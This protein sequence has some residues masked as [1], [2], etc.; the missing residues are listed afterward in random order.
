MFQESISSYNLSS[1]FFIEDIYI[2]SYLVRLRFKLPIK[3]HFYHGSKLY[4]FVSNL[5]GY[6]SSPSQKQ[7]VN[8]VVIYPCES[9]RIH[10]KPGDEYNFQITFLNKNELIINNFLKNIQNI[11]EFELGGDL[12]RKSVELISLTRIQNLTEYEPITGDTFTLRFLTPLRIERKEE[13]KKRGETLFDLKYFDGKHFFKL[14]YK[15]AA[16]LY[17]LNFGFFPSSEIPVN[18]EVEILD[19]YFIWVDSIKEDNTFSLGGIVGFIK[20]KADLNELWRRILWFGQIMHAGKSSAIGFGKYYIEGTGFEEK[21]VKPAKTYSQLILEKE[22]LLTA[23][24]HIKN[25]SEFAGVDGITPDIYE[26]NLEEN[27][28]KLIGDVVRD[29]YKP[30]NLTGIIVPKS[31]SKIRALAIPSVRD[32]IFQRA[33]VQIIGETI[34]NLLEDSSYVY[35]KGLSRAGAAFAIDKARRSG[36]N[37]VLEVDIQSFFD[38]VDWEILFKKIDI[39]FGDDPIS[40]I[41]KDWISC[42]VLFEGITIK[43]NKGLPQGA[44]ISPILANLYL[45]EFDEELQNEFKLVRYADDFVILCKSKEQAENALE[46]VKVVL[47][48]LRLDIHPSKTRITT[49]EEGFQYLGYLFVNSLILDK[50]SDEQIN[51]DFVKLELKPENLPKSSWITLIDFEKIKSIHKNKVQ[52]ITPLTKDEIQEL[53]LDKYPLYITKDINLHLDVDGVEVIYKEDAREIRK[54]YPLKDL[55]SIVFIGTNKISMPAVFKLNKLN[56]P[57]YFCKSTGELRLSIPL[58]NPDYTLWANQ[59]ELTND[60]NFVFQFAKEIVRA[61][62]NNHKVIARRISEKNESRD[63]FNSLLRKVNSVN[64]L[65]ELRGIEGSSAAYFY[66]ILNDNLSDEWKFEKRRKRPPTDPVNAMLSFGYS[67]IYNH[68]STAIQIEGLNPQIGFFHRPSNRYFPLA[69]D[70][71]EEFRHI[72]D[73]LIHYIIKRNMVTRDVFVIDENNYYPCLMTK[74]FRRKFIGLVEE[75]LKIEFSPPNFSRKISY[76]DFIFFQVKNLKT[77][78]LKKE[79]RYKPLWIR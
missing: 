64:S 11:P 48:N 66:N 51:N 17:K 78:I 31:E 1:K 56:I 41:L 18:P 54:K 16:D 27:L 49:F 52:E 12:N 43:R 15:R 30:D 28:N 34:D 26:E 22:N 74:D 2:E 42:D 40:K 38:N 39:L 75:R 65:E 20:L 77:S 36:F 60:Q 6:H 7:K 58:S 70:I 69:S 23:F 55:S 8:D 68:I 61:K 59:L 19:K 67:I 25:N 3:F 29:K 32:R 46:K 73:S 72:I 35:R 45:D 44:V 57:V 14:L 76:K 71:Q 62:I 63:F 53:L 37:Y 4:G 24:R 21:L 50:K 10:Y 5:T 9:G 13:D 33:T 47:Q 79:M